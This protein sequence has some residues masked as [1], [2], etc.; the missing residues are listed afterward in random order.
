MYFSKASSLVRLADLVLTCYSF[1]LCIYPSLNL[2]YFYLSYFIILKCLFVYL[3]IYLFKREREHVCTLA[4]EKGRERGRQRIWSGLC[5]HSR[6]PDARLELTNCEIM[7]WAEV[8]HLINW[9]LYLSYFLKVFLLF[10]YINIFSKFQP[11]WD[12][13]W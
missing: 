10:L 11:L 7:T 8:G 13:L 1:H 9:P 6:E 5:A 2:S 4:W 12:L 3:F